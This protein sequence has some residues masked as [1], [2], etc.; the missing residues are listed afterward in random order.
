MNNFRKEIKN[1]SDAEKILLA[2]E[3][4]DS[5][6]KKEKTKIS[7]AQKAEI[8]RRLD[9]ESNGNM[10]YFSLAEARERIKQLK[11]NV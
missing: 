8:K 10:K 2:E 4:W 9:I 7:S 1:L 5:V 11:K 6:S 3:I